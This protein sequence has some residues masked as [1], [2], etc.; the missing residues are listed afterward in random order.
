M[1]FSPLSE[2]YG[3]WRF[4]DSVM[5]GTVRGPL[6]SLW[7]PRPPLEILTQ[8]VQGGTLGICLLRKYL[9]C[10]GE[11]SLLLDP[12]LGRGAGGSQV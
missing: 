9:R 10:G 5:M 4:S 8:E 2:K 7:F 3:A 12:A 6:L 1:A 11:D